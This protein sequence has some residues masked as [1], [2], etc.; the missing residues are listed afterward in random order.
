[1]MPDTSVQGGE[2]V[3]TASEFADITNRRIATNGIEL[4]IAE[5]GDPDAPLL[6]L[7]HGFPESWF[8][9]RH[10]FAPLAA[11]GYHVVAPDMRGYGDTSAP[12]DPEAYRIDHLALDVVGVI[13]HFGQETA[14]IIGHDWGS[15]VVWYTALLHPDRI[16]AVVGM[17]VPYGGR[18]K[19]PPLDSF[20]AMHGDNFFYIL[21]HNEAGGVAE[22][23]Y[24][25]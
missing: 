5:Q 11:A 2:K 22:A 4:N 15:M 7:L 24:D 20:K 10:Q 23:E 25:C 21:Y 13:D 17:S 19:A 16:N 1:M 3:T 18:A 12:S 9:W 8:S 14:T 6:L